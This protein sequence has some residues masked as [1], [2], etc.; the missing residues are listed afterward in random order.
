MITDKAIDTVMY[1]L[2]LRIFYRRKIFKRWSNYR[3]IVK[4]EEI[5]EHEI[6]WFYPKTYIKKYTYVEV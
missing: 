6:Q 4:F 5:C 3:G 2:G 1:A